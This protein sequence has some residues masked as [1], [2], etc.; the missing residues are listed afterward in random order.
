VGAAWFIDREGVF[1][2][3]QFVAPSGSP[4][5]SLTANDLLRPL[6]LKL[7]TEQGQGVP[8]YSTVLRYA[9]NYTP[10]STDVA[11]SVSD[12]RRAYLAKGWRE[13]ADT[14]SAV[15]TVHLLAGQ[16]VEESLLAEE[17][18]AQAEVERRQTLRG[19]VRRLFEAVVPLTDDTEDV[20]LNDVLELTHSRY[21]LSA[22]ASF[23]V[24]G[25]RLDAAKRELALDI[26]R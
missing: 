2:I 8:Q 14:D 18:D 10:Q 20:D 11:P 1:R 23:R 26:F 19:V 4:V 3:R 5:I 24:I 21:G 12:A 9:K 7:Q 13:V 17:A 15:Q 6:T 25:H 16:V 22:G